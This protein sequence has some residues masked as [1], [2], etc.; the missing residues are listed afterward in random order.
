[1]AGFGMARDLILAER[2]SYLPISGSR[3]SEINI[4]SL[5]DYHMAESADKE[6]INCFDFTS[7]CTTAL[8]S[9]PHT[10]MS[11]SFNWKK[12]MFFLIDENFTKLKF[13]ISI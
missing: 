9:V 2:H 7:E 1:M 6:E 12:N 5:P 3:D 8:Q 10:A 13:L 4:D 11:V